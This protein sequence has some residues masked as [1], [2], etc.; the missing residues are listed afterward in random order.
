MY[1]ARVTDSTAMNA[2][3]TT[4]TLIG[5]ISVP[6][7]AKKIVQVC[8]NVIT[9][10][11]LTTLESISG[12]ITLKCSNATKWQGDQEFLTG[13]ANPLTSG[14]ATLNPVSYATDIEVEPNADILCY[15]TM[16]TALTIN[17]KVRIGLVFAG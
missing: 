2:T 9:A 5:T 1:K 16:D 3:E 8:A 14:V 4:E 10:A 11:G 7:G 13:V 17:N 15:A 12:K 6:L